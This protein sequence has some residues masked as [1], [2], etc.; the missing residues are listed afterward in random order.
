MIICNSLIDNL[1][2]Y[3]FLIPEVTLMPIK[4]DINSN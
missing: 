3:F 1:Q 4:L 2:P